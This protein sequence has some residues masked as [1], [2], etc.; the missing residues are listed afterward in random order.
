VLHAEQGQHPFTPTFVHALNMK[1]V[2]L[3]L[4]AGGCFSI[5]NNMTLI[6]AGLCVGARSAI[7]PAL[8]GRILCAQRPGGLCGPH[9]VW[10][11]LLQRCF[12]L[13]GARAAQQTSPG[14]T[15]GNSVLRTSCCIGTETDSRRGWL[16][17]SL[18]V[19]VPKWR[20]GTAALT[21]AGRQPA[22]HL[23][24]QCLLAWLNA[25]CC[26]S[27]FQTGMAVYG[28]LQGACLPQACV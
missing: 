28:A 23:P 24:C 4:C 6:A 5:H 12:D 1:P 19:V 25:A 15:V 14:T 17:I 13:A 10:R 9:E 20:Q 21:S 18:E 16:R 7:H 2:K 3:T 11:Q 27:V 26:Q 8:S 22:V